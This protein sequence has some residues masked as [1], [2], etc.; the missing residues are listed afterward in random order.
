MLMQVTNLTAAQLNYLD[1]YLGYVGVPG[2]TTA[3]GGN[4][5]SPVPYP[6]DWYTF[7]ANGTTGYNPTFSVHERDMQHKA[8]M[9]TGHSAGEQWNALVQAG[10]VSITFSA[11]ATSRDTEDLLIHAI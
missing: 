5:V 9:W 11:E 8:N 3:I 1:S 4:K 6:F 10:T 7:P 2:V